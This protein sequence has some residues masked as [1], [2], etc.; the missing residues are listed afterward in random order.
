MVFALVFFYKPGGLKMKI[1][2]TL[3]S[4]VIIFGACGQDTIYYNKTYNITDFYENA[5]YYGFVYYENEDSTKIKET[6]Y[7]LTGQIKIERHYIKKQIPT[8]TSK[9]K[10]LDGSYKE[11]FES[12][13]IK[14]ELHYS[15]GSIDGNV[16]T[17]WENGNSKRNDLFEEGKFVKGQ[18]FDSDGQPTKHFDYE[19]A[20]EFPGGEMA[21][22]EYLAKNIRYPLKAKKSGCQGTVFVTFIVNIDGSISDAHI[23]RGICDDADAEALRVVNSMPEW[24]PAKT[25]GE[26]NPVSFNL[27]IRFILK[28]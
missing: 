1:I 24:S 22:M 25:D 6:I 16:L 12:G 4:I 20:A 27:P 5:S 9:V 18:C 17:F 11:W 21:L 23:L 10:I 13:Q 7:F 2:L 26:L 19:V 8:I 14:R 15:D 3:I 28:Y